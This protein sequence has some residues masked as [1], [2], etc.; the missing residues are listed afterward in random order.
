MVRAILALLL[1]AIELWLAIFVIPPAVADSIVNSNPQF[2][3][4]QEIINNMPHNTIFD[5]VDKEI[6][7]R[8]LDFD[9]SQAAMAP[10]IIITIINF[11]LIGFLQPL[12]ISK[13]KHKPSSNSTTRKRYAHQY[14][15]SYTTQ[16]SAVPFNDMLNTQ[17]ANLQRH[18]FE[19]QIRLDELRRVEQ[20]TLD[21]LRRVNEESRLFTE[22]SQ[23]TVTPLEMGGFL[24]NSAISHSNDSH[25]DFGSSNDNSFDTGGIG[26]DF[27]SGG[28]D[29]SSF[30][31][32]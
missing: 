8:R 31:N 17:N 9:K 16:S 12:I 10:R 30:N 7:Q 18:M 13:L 15:T 6:K 29:S 26:N 3:T 2:K 19:E 5:S 14:N 22:Y 32:F 20:M 1:V 24:Q 27:T 23:K 28:F 25:Y 11:G 21:E 4:R